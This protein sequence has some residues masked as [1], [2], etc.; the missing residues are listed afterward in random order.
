MLQAYS[1][2]VV[3]M[4]IALGAFALAA[5]VALPDA[6]RSSADES[7]GATPAPVPKPSV[8][9]N[10]G[11]RLHISDIPDAG[12]A[13]GY[14]I[15]LSADGNI[16]VA[17]APDDDG[18]ALD[19]G[20]AY[21]FLKPSGD[22]PAFGKPAAKLTAPDAAAL[23][24]FGESAAISADGGF[25]VVGAFGN[26]SRKGAAY[27]FAK[28]ATGW[29]DTST[30]AKLTAPDGWELDRFGI[31]VSMS[32]DGGIIAV[33]ARGDDSQKG[34]AY[35]F[36]KPDGAAWADTSDAAKL[37]A[38]DGEAG[39]WFGRA[40]SISGD[41]STVAAGAPLDDSARGAAYM[42]AK[43]DGG[44]GTSAASSSIKLAAEGGEAHDKF[45]M[46]VS[47]SADGGVV[48]VGAPMNDR[49]PGAAYAFVKPT[50]GW[51]SAESG[52]ELT[53]NGVNGDGFGIAVSASGDGEKILVGE[54]GSSFFVFNMPSGGWASASEDALKFDDWEDLEGSVRSGWAVSMN[55]DGSEIAVGEPGRNGGGGDFSV[56]EEDERTGEYAELGAKWGSYRPIDGI[57]Y[58]DRFGRSVSVSED[59]SVAVVGA[60]GRDGNGKDSGAAY[61][62]GE[63]AAGWASATSTPAKLTASDGAAGD[64][65]GRSVSVSGDGGVV[66]IGAPHNDSYNGAVYV[67]T[68][69]AAGWGTGAIT[70]SAKLTA[71]DGARGDW[72]GF[73]VDMSADGGVIAVGAYGVDDGDVGNNGAAYVFVKPASGWGTSPITAETAKLAGE[74]YWFGFSAS[75]SGDGGVVAIGAHRHNLNRGAVYVF[76]K[77]DGGWSS[78][79]AADAKLTAPDRVAS[80][81]GKSLDMSGDGGVIVVGAE[82]GV[83]SGVAYIFTKPLSGWTSTSE[84]EELEPP[85]FD[86]HRALY[87]QGKYGASAAIN[88]NG[89]L[90]AV[91]APRDNRQDQLHGVEVG[92]A[93]VFAKPDCGWSSDAESVKIIASGPSAPASEFGGAVSIGGDLV[94]VG[95]PAEDWDKGG[96][97][98]FEVERPT[99]PP[100]LSVSAPPSPVSEG[101]EAVFTVSL[102]AG[103]AETVSVEYR[104]S[105]GGASPGADYEDAGGTLIFEPC[106]TQETARVSVIADA[107]SEGDETFTLQLHAANGAEIAPDGASAKASIRDVRPA[108]GGSSGGGSGGGGGGGGAPRAP[109]P[110]IAFSPS[111]LSF[112]AK[113]GGDA[114][115]ITRRMEVWNAERGNMGFGMSSDVGW[116]SFSPQRQQVSGGSGARATISVTANIA[117][118]EPG[119]HSARIT[120]TQ[121]SGEQESE[122]FPATLTLTGAD[123]ARTAVSPQ[124]AATVESPD[125]TIALYLPPGAAPD[126]LEIGLRKLG[127]TALTAPS[128]NERVAL[129]VDLNTYRIG[130]THPIA[131]EY[132]DGADLRFALP[133]GEETAC[134]DGMARVYRVSGNDWTLLEHRCETDAD[135]RA[136]A[137][138]TLTNFSQYAM[139]LAQAVAVTPTATPTPE[140]TP[141]P[142]PSPEPTAVATPE[143]VATPSPTP[144]PSPT[145][146][147]E[148]TPTATP[149]PTP[150]PTA[151]PSPTP[152]PTATSTPSPRPTPTLAPTATA[153][154][155]PKPTATAI[156]TATPAPTAAVPTAA[157]AAS[158]RVSPT[159]TASAP[160]SPV[161]EEAEG[162]GLSGVVI[163]IAVG[164]A[165][166]AIAV[167]VWLTI[168]R[169]RRR[170]AAG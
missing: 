157:I 73:S 59:E 89:D 26:E 44:W 116:L 78:A 145:A 15:A 127:E 27:V 38:D 110:V 91:G 60:Y 139:T 39:D 160:G 13:L 4:A 148:P 77:P 16:V 115:A 45:G 35:V 120:I 11:Q 141:E 37:T 24:R 102:S 119:S 155:S 109:D 74:G 67:F 25:I 1:K 96:A 71:S 152:H 146:T 131:T 34:A 32:A 48:A 161:I 50:G 54:A 82:R 65:F 107:E 49:K 18:G 90:I 132:P 106:D 104:L 136:W 140:P 138:T 168:T 31:S 64:W 121:L 97:Y 41:G 137:I 28:P 93:Y 169:T 84:A 118:L 105:G 100:T 87:G 142:T 17:G 42:F 158:A 108:T 66:A 126:R 130:G 6:P 14:S 114:D 167:V 135:G 147:P 72:F 19:A 125:S 33:G 20:A 99:A 9:V 58:G 83:S 29:A 2:T 47:A 162:G 153:I 61:V 86:R 95:A 159:P 8:G 134:E 124:S 123:S 3:R 164:I 23:N 40:V 51:A 57:D 10:A 94:S 165:L 144:T 52:I 150:S 163:A 53:S 149:S 76:A 143:S 122:S 154:P 56:Y 101:G 7:G 117:G 112:I 151:T 22:M 98:T 62:F 113:H 68:K 81:F 75:V 85:D 80:R 5:L 30:A 128:E 156:A 92:S 43:P 46:S 69:P 12:D 55:Y 21:V 170:R 111:A 103:S 166:V 63:P 133:P 88:G 129:A 36:T 70:D 79:S